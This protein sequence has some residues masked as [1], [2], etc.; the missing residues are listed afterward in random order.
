M[1]D[2]LNA[3]RQQSSTA[4]KITV[5]LFDTAGAAVAGVTP[6]LTID[7]TQSGTYSAVSGAASASDANGVSWWTGNA[8]D[9]NT[10]G[11]CR[12]KVTGT[13]SPRV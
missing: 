2:N 10:L 9:R 1:I 8:T 12:V 6:T 4:D 7:K 11:P 5:Y 3:T 13:W